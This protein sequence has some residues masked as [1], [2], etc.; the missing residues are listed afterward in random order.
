MSFFGE[1]YL[2]STRPF[3]S[4]E[5]TAREVAYLE[6]GFAGLTACPGPWWI[7]AVAMAGTPRRSTPPGP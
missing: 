3:L 6:R 7:W 4:P 2:R 1:L 5:T